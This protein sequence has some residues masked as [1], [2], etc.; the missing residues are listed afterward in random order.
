MDVGP[1]HC[2]HVVVRLVQGFCSFIDLKRNQK[3]IRACSCV[4]PLPS[5]KTPLLI[6]ATK[7]LHR[8]SNNSSADQKM[9]GLSV[10]P[11]VTF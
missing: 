10:F 4:K 2:G 3:R 8:M 6:T 7:E 11:D 9:P 1:V 5:R